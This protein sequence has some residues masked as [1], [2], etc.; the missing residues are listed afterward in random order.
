MQPRENILVQISDCLALNGCDDFIFDRNAMF[1]VGGLSTDSLPMA[2]H[3][4]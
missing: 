3:I 2:S 1:L 4:S